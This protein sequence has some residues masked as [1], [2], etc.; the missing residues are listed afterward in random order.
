VLVPVSVL[1][2]DDTKKA[3]LET[4]CALIDYA[5]AY[6]AAPPCGRLNHRR[7]RGNFTRQDASG[8]L[9]PYFFNRRISVCVAPCGASAKTP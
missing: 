2:L 4:S 7:T 5:A 3:Q 6:A 8:M 1:V 9:K